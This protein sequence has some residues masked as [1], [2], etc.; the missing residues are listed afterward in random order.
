[1][2]PN[3]PFTHKA[4]CDLKMNAVHSMPNC[5]RDIPTVQYVLKTFDS[6]FY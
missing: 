6:E 1:M 4:F 2:Q 3:R 5:V